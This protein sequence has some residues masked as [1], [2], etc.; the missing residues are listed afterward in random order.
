MYLK[1]KINMYMDEY[2]ENFKQFVHL[3]ILKK[4][5]EIC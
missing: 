3:E 2:R 4:V 5:S 1:V